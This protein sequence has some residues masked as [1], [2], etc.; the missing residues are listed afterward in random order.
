MRRRVVITGI[1]LVTPFGCDAPSF[2]RALADGQSGVALIDPIDEL[3][4]GPLVGAPVKDFQPGAHIDPKSLRLMS[5][6]VTFGVAAAQLAA[7]DSGLA[8]DRLDPHRLGAFVGSRGHS[9]DRHD[10]MPAVRRAA[11]SGTF[12]LDRF[13]AEGLPLVHP[14]WLLKGLANN[15]LYFVSVKYNAQGMNNN[16]SMG[17]VAGTMA[18]GEAFRTIQRGYVDAAFAGGYD[19]S[20]DA[21]RAEM[22]SVSGLVTRSADPGG[23]SRPFDRRRDGF[24]LAEGAGFVILETLDAAISRGAHLYGE[25]L[26]YGCATS[27][28]SPAR[29]GP[30][31]RGF[32]GALCAALADAGVGCPDAVFTLGLATQSSDVEETRALKIVFGA[33]AG[34]IPAPAPK[35]M[36]GNT[37]A[38]SG[39]IETAAALLALAEGSV[40]PTINLT[41]PDAACDL[42]YVAGAGARSLS[43]RAVA[44]N[45]ANLGGAHAALVLGRVQ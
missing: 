21:D 27:S 1:G 36:I 19:S 18:I 32:A 40:P 29:L 9:S 39:A 2:W 45:N 23:A 41:E 38:A 43:L 37:F 4:G 35:S 26:G 33:D 8:F 12:S 24:V 16:I 15:V 34:S 44:I 42:D 5:P 31:A 14:M 17:G 11:S 3:E 25:V 7:A 28:P 22:F 20:L 6:A 13:G 30:S 10:L